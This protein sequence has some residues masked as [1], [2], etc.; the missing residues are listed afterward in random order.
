MESNTSYILLI[1]LLILSS[2]SSY[3]KR[4]RYSDKGL[5]V[6]VF[7]NRKMSYNQHVR[8]SAA[9]GK[10]RHFT[11]VTRDNGLTAIKEEQD[12]LHRG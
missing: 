9:V 6:A 1:S 8:L 2:C 12:R 5:R 4:T 3:V 11:L 10:S 7:V